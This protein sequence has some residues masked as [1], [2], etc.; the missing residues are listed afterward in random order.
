M[1]LDNLINSSPQ[2][3]GVNESED[4]RNFFFAKRLMNDYLSISVSSIFKQ[5]GFISLDFLDFFYFRDGR[6]DITV[7]NTNFNN[8]ENE[9]VSW[10]RGSLTLDYTNLC[11]LLNTNPSK[12]LLVNN[13]Y[14]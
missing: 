9:V 8:R 13:N 10:R 5:I 3:G 2:G 14:F 7:K 4:I 6:F 11:E 1:S 12:A